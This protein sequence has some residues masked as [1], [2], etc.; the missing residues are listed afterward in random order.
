M[1]TIYGQEI[2]QDLILLDLQ[3]LSVILGMDW[4]VTNH[5][6]I[7]CYRKKVVFRQTR[8]LEVVVYR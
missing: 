3:G 2:E 7:D 1:I 4:L 6:S 5:A 8:L